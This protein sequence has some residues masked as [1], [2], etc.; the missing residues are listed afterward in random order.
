LNGAERIRASRA[1]PRG[2]PERRW[3]STRAGSMGKHQSNEGGGRGRLQ[4]IQY[5]HRH[6][7]R[8]RHRGIAASRQR[9]RVGWERKVTRAACERRNKHSAGIHLAS[10][11]QSSEPSSKADHSTQGG[12]L[13]SP[14]HFSPFFS[15]SV[16]ARFHICHPAHPSV[17]FSTRSM[18]RTPT[19]IRLSLTGHL[20]ISTNANIKGNNPKKV[21]PQ[22]LRAVVSSNLC[23][24]SWRNLPLQLINYRRQSSNLLSSSLL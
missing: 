19:R 13:F 10:E 6:R 2:E 20:F 8:H 3:S 24:S 4:R 1:G 9:S 15:F 22:R 11:S 7:H 14:V 16:S 21:L 17:S 5:S 12:S 23:T 18:R